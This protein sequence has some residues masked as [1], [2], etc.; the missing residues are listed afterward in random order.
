MLENCRN[1]SAIHCEHVEVTST[2]LPKKHVPAEK[3][4]VTL[5]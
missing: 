1:Y 2:L 4:Q 5:F 3:R